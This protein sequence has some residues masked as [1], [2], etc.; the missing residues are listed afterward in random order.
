MRYAKPRNTLSFD[1][2][3]L[4]FIRQHYGS[5]HVLHLTAA[6]DFS[7]DFERIFLNVFDN[8]NYNKIVPIYIVRVLVFSEQLSILSKH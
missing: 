4:S 3:S 8:D 5:D 2:A 7:R 6:K 1:L